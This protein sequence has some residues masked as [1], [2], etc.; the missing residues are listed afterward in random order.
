MTYEKFS[1]AY[2]IECMLTLILEI[3]FPGGFLQPRGEVGGGGV[4][5]KLRGKVALLYH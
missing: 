5:V 3:F 4:T 2:N 1:A